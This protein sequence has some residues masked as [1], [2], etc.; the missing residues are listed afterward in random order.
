[1]V[2]ITHKSIQEMEYM[3]KIYRRGFIVLILILTI[4]LLWNEVDLINLNKEKSNS[5]NRSIMNLSILPDEIHR[6]LESLNIKASELQSNLS[7]N[8][9]FNFTYLKLAGEKYISANTPLIVQTYYKKSDSLVQEIVKMPGNFVGL[10][11]SEFKSI[12]K[13]W[14]VKEYTAGKLMILY[15]SLNELSP[16][17]KNNIHLGV[18]EGKVAI[19]YGESGQR[20]LKKL[21]EIELNDLPLQEQNNLKSGI[22]VSSNEELLSVLDSLIS[23]INMD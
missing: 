23:Q 16:T 3:L 22:S 7:D 8:K 11:I 4:I 17:D 6:S 9:G 18:Q 1:M 21:T 19:F 12:S 13:Q 10:T 5:R 15:R 2:T 20:N 14:E